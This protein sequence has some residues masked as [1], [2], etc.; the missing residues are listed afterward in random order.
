MWLANM[1]PLILWHSHGINIIYPFIR[2]NKNTITRLES[3]VHVICG[4]SLDT[5]EYE[6]YS[7]PAAAAIESL[8]QLIYS[9]RMSSPN[10]HPGLANRCA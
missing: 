8:N 1:I 3:I 9:P 5:F 2:E 10:L 4:Q 6:Q 7:E